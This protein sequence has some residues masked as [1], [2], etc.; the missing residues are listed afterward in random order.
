M[1]GYERRTGR[2]G[3]GSGRPAK[4]Y[5]VAPELAAIEFPA[6]RYESLLGHVLDAMPAR[7]R[8]ARLH[9]VGV[10]FGSD[11]AAAAGLRPARS[12]RAGFDRV[13]AAVGRLGYQ[14]SVEEVSANG[15]VIATPRARCAR[16]CGAA[17]GGGRD[18]PR[19]VGRAHGA[20]ALGGGGR[21][22]RVRDARLPGGSRL[23]SRAD[24]PRGRAP[25]VRSDLDSKDYHGLMSGCSHRS[26]MR[27]AEFAGLEL[28]TA[29]GLVMTPRSTSVGLVERVAPPHR[30]TRGRRRGRGHRL[31][32]DRD[33][34]RAGGS[35]GACLGD[36]RQRGGRCR[37]PG[38][39]PS[40]TVWTCRFVAVTCWNRSRGRSTSWSRIFR[41]CRASTARFTPISTTSLRRRVRARRRP[42]PLS[43]VFATRRPI[44]SRSTVCSRSNCAGS[45]SRS[46]PPRLDLFDAAL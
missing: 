28:I 13:C 25:V 22:R 32:R 2:T 14:A 18:R 31:R 30:R 40:A 1:P 11:L 10:A 29:P 19:H 38:A 16:S 15:A 39:M 37:S 36:R 44:G 9:D 21:A 41:I 12:L 24:H 45:C 23:V 46:R 7:G 26:R 8:R 5:S 42:R 3:P 4:T 35:A 33:R 27:L 43:G 20:R 6:R 34:D 17:S